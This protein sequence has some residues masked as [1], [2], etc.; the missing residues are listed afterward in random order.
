QKFYGRI[1]A[2]ALPSRSQ[3]DWKEQFGR[4]LAE[5]MACGLPCVGSDS[6][7][8]P[9]VMGPGGLVVPEG[10]AL[11]LARALKRLAGSAALRRRLG[12]AGR[13]RARRSFD[14]GALVA[15]LGRFL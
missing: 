2:L 7:A 5:A 3:R 11:A 15:D 1:D 12:A 13:A 6:G 10:D 9:E 4:V 14:T 8:I